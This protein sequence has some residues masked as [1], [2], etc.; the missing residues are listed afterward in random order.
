MNKSGNRGVLWDR[1]RTYYASK[2]KCTENGTDAE[3]RCWLKQSEVIDNREKLELYF[4]PSGPSKNR[5]PLYTSNINDAMKR[6]EFKH[7]HFL[8]MGTVPIDFDKVI[9]KY[10]TMNLCKL[11]RSGYTQIG[12]VFNL[13]PSTKS[14]SHWV[15]AF[16][17]VQKRYIGFIDSYGM[18]PHK[19]IVS[20]INRLQRQAILCLHR[21]LE[22]KHNI[23]E[24]QQ[25]NTECGMYCIYFLTKLVKGV[26]FERV[27]NTITHDKVVAEFRKHTFAGRQK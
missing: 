14:G 19:N 26:S 6:L 13:D 3:E 11:V 20:F 25:Y 7:K 15:C 24:H 23:N 2:N 9:K 22:Y 21:E 18:N 17:D 5:V 10:A 12:F 27:V 8:F 16:V 1:I 4:K